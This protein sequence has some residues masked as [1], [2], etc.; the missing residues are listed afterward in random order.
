M[1]RAWTTP[2]QSLLWEESGQEILLTPWNGHPKFIQ[3]ILVTPG[4]QHSHWTP[5]DAW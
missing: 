1:S 5:P 2:T 3:K 4:C